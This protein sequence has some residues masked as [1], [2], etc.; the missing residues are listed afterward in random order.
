MDP[1]KNK[2]IKVGSLQT[3]VS[4]YCGRTS[5]TV[6]MPVKCSTSLDGLIAIWSTAKVNGLLVR[7]VKYILENIRMWLE[8]TLRF[9]NLLT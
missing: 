7:R 1:F 3:L 4:G 8:M 5:Y 2:C 6:S 9:F